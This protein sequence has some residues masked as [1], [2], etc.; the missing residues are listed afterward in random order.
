MR[1]DSARFSRVK[2]RLILNSVDKWLTKNCIKK[3]K[4]LIFS[5]LIENR[6]PRTELL[7]LNSVAAQCFYIM[8]SI[9]NLQI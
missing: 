3:I 6:V 8:L 4:S 7:K 1:P 9:S 5:D 2:S